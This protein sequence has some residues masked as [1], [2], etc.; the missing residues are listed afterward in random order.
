MA[1]ESTGSGNDAAAPDLRGGFGERSLVWVSF[2][3]ATAPR[4]PAR[5]SGTCV[6]VL[7]CS[8]SRWPRRSLESR[9]W[10][11]TAVSD[12][13]VPP[14][15]RS[16][17]MRPAKGSAM[18]F[19]TNAA[20]GPASL[21][22]TGE[23]VAVGVDGGEPALGRRRDE[24]HDGVE[25]RLRADRPQSGGAH[26]RKKLA[27]RGRR[28]QARRELVLRQCAVGEERVHQLF[29]GLGDHLDEPGPRLGGPV[30]HRRG[31]FAFGHLASPLN[32]KA[33]IDTRSTTPLKPFSS[34]MGSWMGT[35]SRAQSRCRSRA[36]D[37]RWRDRGRGG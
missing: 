3:F 28:A 30:G 32:V 25:Q 23:G 8:T 11:W 14:M 19:Q 10:L 15:I 24:G 9:V 29:V 35:I 37:R 17:V 16:M 20:Y 2:S 36:P 6:W 1:Y 21:A 4:S 12:L 33:F 26:E 34:P 22:G 18:V 7:P 13:S 5:S 27:G 31:D